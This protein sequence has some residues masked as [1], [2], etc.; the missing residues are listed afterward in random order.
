MPQ[1]QRPSWLPPPS[2]M[3]PSDGVRWSR[4]KAAKN[5]G[6]RVDEW[7]TSAYFDDRLERTIATTIKVVCFDHPIVLHTHLPSFVYHAR[8]IQT[9]NVWFMQKIEV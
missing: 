7:A 3:V 8:C 9:C 6:E 1:L 5:A 2:V 4:K